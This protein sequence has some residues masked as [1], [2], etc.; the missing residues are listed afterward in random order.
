[1]RG[2]YDLPTL[3][4]IAP[5]IRFPKEPKTVNLNG[6]GVYEYVSPMDLAQYIKNFAASIDI[7]QFDQ[8]FYNLKGGE[9]FKDRLAE[10]YGLKPAD[11][12]PCEYHPDGRVPLPIPVES[13]S[14]TIAVI[15]DV[16]DT[17]RTTNLIREHSPIASLLYVAKKRTGVLRP[18]G[19]SSHVVEVDD[20]WLGGAG[21][22]LETPGDG[23][24][25]DFTRDFPGI[26]AKIPQQITP[27]GKFIY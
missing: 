5:Y 23:M 19:L 12:T 10:A 24:P 11:F 1:M 21:M 27:E 26:V 22:N 6:I 3:D 16:R 20:V 2:E 4:Y 15:D 13:R 7:T 18:D 25:A 17:V 9:W 8:L 14:K